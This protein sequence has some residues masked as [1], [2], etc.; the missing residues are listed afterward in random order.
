MLTP[1]MASMTMRT[2]STHAARRMTWGVGAAFGGGGGGLVGE[3]GEGVGAPEVV[4]APVVVPAVARVLR[5]AGGARSLTT[6]A[7][8]WG[9]AGSA[10]AGGGA[11]ATWVAPGCDA[12]F[13]TG[14]SPMATPATTATVPAP[15]AVA[16]CAPLRSARATAPDAPPNVR[17]SCASHATGNSSHARYPVETRRNARTMSGSKWS[18]PQRASSALADAGLC[19]RRYD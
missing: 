6:G 13:E 16:L 7:A 1:G 11:V 19:G 18:P 14:A 12:G 8:G 4:G 9:A 10:A 3:G 2:G 15:T 17:A 5:A